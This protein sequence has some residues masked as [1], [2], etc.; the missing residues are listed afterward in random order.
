MIVRVSGV[1]QFELHDDGV[2]KLEKLDGEMTNALHAGNVDEFHRALAGTIEFVCGAGTPLAAD[3]VVP[4]DVIV[5]PEDI[6]LEEAQAFFTDE[7][8][9]KPLPA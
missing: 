1:G 6:S 8:L 2:K 3:R 4:S 7:N 5:P 9:M